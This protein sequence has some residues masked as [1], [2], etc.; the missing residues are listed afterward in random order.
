MDR[1]RPV[2][3]EDLALI[4]VIAGALVWNSASGGSAKLAYLAG[5]AVSAAMLLVLWIAVR[6]GRPS[7]LTRPPRPAGQRASVAIVLGIGCIVLVLLL[8]HR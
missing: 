1:P 8:Q 6:T 7:W 2:E 3:P 4:A 5:L